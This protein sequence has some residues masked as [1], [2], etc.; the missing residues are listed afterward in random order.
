[1]DED[2]R[3]KASKRYLSQLIL[4]Y[5][6]GVFLILNL[7]LLLGTEV[8]GFHIN[9]NFLDCCP[10]APVSAAAA[11]SSDKPLSSSLRFDFCASFCSILGV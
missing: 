6:C 8:K 5:C 9:R 7:F 11:A 2:K 10:T 1:M 3:R 4:G